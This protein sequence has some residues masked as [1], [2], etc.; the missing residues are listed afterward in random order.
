MKGIERAA[1]HRGDTKAR[2]TDNLGVDLKGAIVLDGSEAEQSSGD[3]RGLVFEF[4]QLGAVL[5]ANRFP[6]DACPD[7]MITTS[8]QTG[9]TASLGSC[10]HPAD[11]SLPR[12]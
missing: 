11:E 5:A 10:E 4:P 2:S 12:N 8:N 6:E 9:R 1:A 3:R 7:V